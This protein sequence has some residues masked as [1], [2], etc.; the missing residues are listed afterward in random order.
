MHATCEET[1]PINQ[2]KCRPLP[3]NSNI[4]IVKGRNN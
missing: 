1:L 4:P 3:K 2:E